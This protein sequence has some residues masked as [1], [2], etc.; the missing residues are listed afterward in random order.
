MYK[1]NKQSQPHQ[2]LYRSCTEARLSWVWVFKSCFSP[3]ITL[4]WWKKH[5]TMIALS[6]FKMSH[7]TRD[8]IL[9]RNRDRSSVQLSA[10]SAK[11][12][13]HNCQ[14]RT[15][16][17][18]STQ[19]PQALQ[20]QYPGEHWQLCSSSSLGE[21]C[22]FRLRVEVCSCLVYFGHISYQIWPRFERT[23]LRKPGAR[24]KIKTISTS[25]LIL[26]LVY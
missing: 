14:H 3:S 19:L 10:H 7:V 15:V 22:L 21:F 11:R 23:V 25:R 26:C 13:A 18:S 16:Q 9:N 2:T 5:Q 6:L 8:I 17:C 20:P 1:Q 4:L 12:I 24:D